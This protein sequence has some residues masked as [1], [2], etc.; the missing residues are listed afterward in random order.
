MP[1]PI[2]SSPRVRALMA[3]AAIASIQSAAAADDATPTRLSEDLSW[4]EVGIRIEGDS[5]SVDPA[6]DF[7]LTLTV[8]APE[9][10]QVDVPDLRSRLEGFSSAESFFLEPAVAG[11]RRTASQRWRLIPQPCAEYRLAPLAVEVRDNSSHPASVSWFATRPVVFAAAD[12]GVAADGDP[13]VSPKPAWI[14]PT[15]RSVAKWSAFALLCALAAAAIA[16]LAT[17]IRRK[18]AEMRMS[19]RERALAELGRLL[20]RDLVNKGL[21]KDFYVELTHV[22]RRYIERAHGIHAAEQTTQEFLAAA[23]GRPEFAGEVL[24]RLRAFLESADLVKFAGADATP[25]MADDAVGTARGYIES[26]SAA[27]AAAQSAAASAGAAKPAKE[28]AR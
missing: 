4:G 20:G 21:Y 6:R 12:L 1:L 15:A 11:G 8:D 9:R 3:A 16:W 26:D 7:F 14:P 23:A 2:L 25:R 13:E 19:P 5:A 22:V 24:W 17:R 28:D 27:Q 18:V 10:L